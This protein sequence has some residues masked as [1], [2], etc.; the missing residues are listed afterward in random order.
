VE[1]DEQLIHLSRYIHLNPVS[2]SIIPE[3]M[4][5][6]YP[7]SSYPEYLFLSIDGITE[8]ELVLGPFRSIED[9]QEFVE[10]QIDYAKE[11]DSIKHLVF[12]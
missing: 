6:N 1:T 12:E 5:N 9:Y 2:S 10:N 8:K 4:I 11:L 7:W 3:N